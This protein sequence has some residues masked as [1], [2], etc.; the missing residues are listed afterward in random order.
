MANFILQTFN[1]EVRL[2]CLTLSMEVQM[3]WFLLNIAL[4]EEFGEA[5][6]MDYLKILC[7]EWW[8]VHNFE[9]CFATMW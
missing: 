2:W 6:V 4:P 3:S 8:E 5:S 1:T 7:Q 9:L